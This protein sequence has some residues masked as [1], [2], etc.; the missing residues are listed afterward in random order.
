[1][2]VPAVILRNLALQRALGPAEVGCSPARH[3]AIPFPYQSVPDFP[4]W[5]L[6]EPHAS[7]SE[8]TGKA[9]CRLYSAPLLLCFIVE[10]NLGEKKH[11]LKKPSPLSLLIRPPQAAMGDNEL[12]GLS[13]KEHLMTVFALCVCSI[14]CSQSSHYE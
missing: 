6:P 10:I 1:M 9:G 13:S 14:G 2:P 3:E 4:D 8:G 7:A 5:F 12:L 11:Y